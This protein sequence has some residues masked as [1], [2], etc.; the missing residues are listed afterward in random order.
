MNSY[1]PHPHAQN[2]PILP[3]PI[4]SPS[5]LCLTYDYS[6]PPFQTTH[7]IPVYSS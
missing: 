2:N 1:L 6:H 5:L 4:K 3:P 7:T